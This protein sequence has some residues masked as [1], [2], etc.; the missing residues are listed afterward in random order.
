MRGGRS[1]PAACLPFCLKPVA[2]PACHRRP[3]PFCR[4]SSTVRSTHFMS[5]SRQTATRSSSAEASFAP[6]PGT[7]SARSAPSPVG[8]AA[9]ARHSARASTERC[10][11]SPSSTSAPGRSLSLAVHCLAVSGSGM[12]RTGL[13]PTALASAAPFAPWR[14]SILT[15]PAPRRPVCMPRAPR[16]P[17]ATSSAGPARSGKESA[18]SAPDR[19]RRRSLPGSSSRASMMARDP[20][21]FSAA[22]SSQWAA[23][24]HSRLPATTGQAG[25]LPG[26]A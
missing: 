24:R 19:P 16:E 21:S 2:N 7:T 22:S 12:A 5:D 20:C 1:L 10:M 25:S 3:T 6:A 11:P 13:S 15:M 14:R 26:R 18:L 9:R 17:R 8:T 4:C 23:C